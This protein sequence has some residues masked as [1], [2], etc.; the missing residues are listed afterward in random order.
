MSVP[1]YQLYINGQWVDAADGG[2][3]E[4]RNPYNGELLGTVPEATEQDVR[5]AVGAASAAKPVM[6]ELTAL[7]RGTI[8]RKT[9]VAIRDCERELAHCL[10]SESGK[11]WKFALGEVRRAAETFGFAA[12]EARRLHGETIPMD[13]ATGGVGR[14]GFY[15]RVPVGVVAAISPFNFP[16]NLVAHKVAPAIAAGCTLVLKPSNYTPLTAVKLTELLIEA[17]LPPG[18]LNLIMGS[19]AGAGTWLTTD[20]R[21]DKITF[22]GSPGVGRTILKNAGLKKVTME[23]GSNSATLIEPDANLDKAIPACITGAYANS[24]QV[25]ISVQRIYIHESVYEAFKD[26]FVQGVAQLKVG[27]PLDEATDVGP[28]ITEREAIRVETWI[29]EALSEGARVLIGGERRGSVYMPTVLENVHEKM[30]VMCQEVFGPTVSLV[31]Y[32][33]FN[34]ALTKIDDSDFGLQAGLFTNDLS[35]VLTAVRRLNVGGVIINDVPT[36]RVDQMPYGGN[37]DSGIGREGPRFAVEEMTT[38]RMVVM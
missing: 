6:A 36:F 5:A 9:S 4:I 23:L 24:G 1:R 22:T 26:R 2:V 10:A 25:C 20:P 11:A 32:R 29:N 16:I 35:K 14:F 27:D 3:A 30:R 19:G 17:G 21:V 18:A 7:Q 12:D 15:I 37:K 38:I 13:A 28:L 34:D 33:D 31:P 8:L